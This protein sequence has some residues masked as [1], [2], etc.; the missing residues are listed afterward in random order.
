MGK[1]IG[2]LTKF[3]LLSLA[4][5]TGCASTTTSGIVGV[6]RMQ[7]L[8]VPAATINQ[9]GAQAYAAM[10]SEASSKSTLNVD[11]ELT[12]R[13]RDI[14]ARLI[15]HVGVYR[16]DAQD[17]TWEINVF[18]TDELNAFCLPGGKIGFHKGIITQLD[19]TDD[20][21]AS[22]MGHE[23]A[24]ALREHGREKVSQQTLAAVVV[25]GLAASA[26]SRY[27]SGAY[28][29]GALAAQLFLHLP[30]S[31]HMESEADAMGLELMARAG[32][33]P[34]ASVEVWRKMAQ[35]GRSKPP[36]FLSTH[37]SG[38]TRIADIEVLLPKVRPLHAAAAMSNPHRAVAQIVAPV[39]DMDTRTPGT[40][41]SLLGT[42]SA[43]TLVEQAT[44]RELGPES[45]QLRNKGLAMSCSTDPR[46]YLIRR[47]AGIDLYEIECTDRTVL[48][49][50]CVLSDCQPHVGEIAVK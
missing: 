8:M 13:V 19:L 23:M 37:P 26:E 46:A 28:Q 32:Y 40:V 44:T 33:D 41:S 43:S 36:E 31:R 3:G 24:H 45:A 48:R 14:G 50:K 38:P 49:F 27:Q 11:A 22:I 7:L 9:K 2:C 1:L 6:Q 29:A 10:T 39:V 20:E 21:I 12:S 5:L 47:A 4:L 42:E 25:A 30:F 35:H 18:D 17:W 15:P 34:S 16:M